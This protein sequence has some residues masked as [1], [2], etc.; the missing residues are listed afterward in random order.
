[1]LLDRPGVARVGGSQN[2]SFA[3]DCPSSVSVPEGDSS[4]GGSRPAVSDH[5]GDAPVGAAL[6]HSLRTDGDGDIGVG[7]GKRVK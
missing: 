3:T 4:K 2:G 6:N 1:M 7:E 5:P